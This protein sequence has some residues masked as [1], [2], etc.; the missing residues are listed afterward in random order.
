[1]SLSL[2]SSPP[3]SPSQ[4]GGVYPAKVYSTADPSGTGCIQMYI[5]QIFGSMPV[6]I[7]APPCVLGGGVPAVGDIVWCL[8]QGGD[9][10]YPTYLPPLPRPSPVPVPAGRL[11]FPA[12]TIGTSVTQLVSSIVTY[13][14]NGMAVSNNALV[15]PFPGTYSVKSTVSFTAGSTNA[16]LGTA[17]FKNNIAVPAPAGAALTII[18]SF[19]V[20]LSFSDD[21]RLAAGDA[22]SLGAIQSAGTANQTAG[23]LAVAFVTRLP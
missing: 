13:I 2:S 3:T 21:F 4:Y 1:M 15:V 7:W 19:G 17:I 6:K 12:Q 23:Q 18:P 20:D 9:P 14:E 16:L 10:S 11:S 5:P 8:F 22:I